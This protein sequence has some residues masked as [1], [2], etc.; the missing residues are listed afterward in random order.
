MQRQLWLMEVQGLTKAKAYD[1][2]RREFYRLRQQE[3][4]ERRIAIEEARYVGAYFGKN[5]LEVGQ[6][7]EDM[8]FEK[9]KV[10]AQ[11]E[12]EAQEARAS[13]GVET[14]S[15]EEAEDGGSE[16]AEADVL[17]TTTSEAPAQ[18]A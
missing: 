1:Q 7:L 18:T 9:W 12:T 15:I 10:W 2:S 17:D 8:E 11:K 3:E 4:V 14:F 5:R 13:A 16:F 6:F